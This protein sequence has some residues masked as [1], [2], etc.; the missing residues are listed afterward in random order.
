MAFRKGAFALL[1]DLFGCPKEGQNRVHRCDGGHALGIFLLALGQAFVHLVLARL[2]G[3]SSLLAKVLG[4]HRHAFAIG[5][6]NQHGAGG[7]IFGNF[8]PDLVKSVKVTGSPLDKLFD[9]ALA[10]AEPVVFA[11][12]SR[13]SS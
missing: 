11:M 3:F 8:C 13:V 6:E 9:L 7:S 5:A 2:G 4:S 12:L 1:N 10:D